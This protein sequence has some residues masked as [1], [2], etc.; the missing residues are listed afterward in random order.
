M[1]GVKG[2]TLGLAL[3]G[4]GLR[5]AAHIG[6]LQVFRDAGVPI[7][8]ISGTSA[9][10]IVAGLY[11]AGVD[12]DRMEEMATKV[13]VNDLVRLK[14]SPR[15]LIRM[16][17]KVL[18]DSLGI[19]GNGFNDV[20]IGF[21]DLGPLEHRL[22]QASCGKYFSQLDIP[23]ALVAT[24][25]NSGETVFFTSETMIPAEKPPNSVFITDIP[26][27][28]AAQ[29]SSTIPGVFLPISVHG[30][31]L[32]DGGVKDIVPAEIL[33]RMGVG[34]VI[35]VDLGYAGKR[36]EPV[37]NILEV[38]TQSVDIMGRELAEIRLRQ[39]ADIVIH[40]EI[41]DVGLTDFDRIPECIIRGREAAR[42]AL[43]DIL[44]LLRARGIPLD[45]PSSGLVFRIAQ[46]RRGNK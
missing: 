17:L 45:T 33:R 7:H 8:V 2:P 46:E 1:L 30:R 22:S 25:I 4:G 6:I 12:P 9:G 31:T 14:V 39:Y 24:D 18:R 29:A 20:P 23:C 43:P 13:A 16:I 5:G 26:V 37:D 11:A 27:S 36:K 32:V 19:S 3:G 40:P 28:R 21:L 42:A 38:V 15:T 44:Y 10:S 35:A 34:T 41:Y